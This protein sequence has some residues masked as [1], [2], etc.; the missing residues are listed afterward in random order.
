M[1]RILALVLS[2]LPAPLLA[3]GLFPVLFDVTGVA[4]DDV[5]NVRQAPSGS[6]ALI[7]TL[8]PD[9]RGVE[10]MAA[11]PEG[12]WGLVNSNESRGWVSMRYL[13]RQP[14]QSWDANEP[15]GISPVPLECFGTEPF[16]SVTLSTGDTIAYASP[17][18]ADPTPQL[19]HFAPLWSAAGPTKR[20]FTARL[21][22]GDDLT[23]VITHEICS[24]GM[25]DRAYGLSIDL[26]RETATARWLMTGCCRLAAE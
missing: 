1:I 12:S 15:F 18:E 10:V 2:L 3:Q 13:A 19:G 23:G 22:N 26:V 24:D 11:N 9:A 7:G 16:W 14:G 25:S 17:S 6:A 20:G 8:A 4:A 5:L 21:D